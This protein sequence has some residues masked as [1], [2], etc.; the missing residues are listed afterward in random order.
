MAKFIFITGGVVSSLGKGI[1]ASSIGR[2]LK[3]KGFKIFMQKFD[4][5]INVD[6]GTLSPY[7]HGEVYV[8]DDG[9]ETDLDLGHYER[10]T[11]ESLTKLSNITTG[12]IYSEV[13]RKEREGKYLGKTVQVIP[14]ITNEIKLQLKRAEDKSGADII[15]TEIG[16][17]V[18]DIESLP[19]LEAIRQF[20]RERGIENT[21]FVH[22]VLLPY[23]NKSGEIKTKPAQHSTKELGSLGIQPDMIVL[24]SEVNINNE[25]R[26]KISLFCD[27]KKENVFLSKDVDVIYDVV[28]NLYK[29]KID[30]QIC[31]HFKLT[32]CDA[33]METWENLVKKIKNLKSTIKIALVGKYV[34]LHD[35][36]LSVVEALNAAGYA[37]D[38]K[39]EIGWINSEELD[40]VNAKKVLKDYHGIVVPGGFG[41]RG[42]EGK[43]AAL[44]YAR[45]HQIP[46]LGICFGL[47]LMAIEFARN[48]LKLPDA[49][50]TEF[51]PLCENPI[52]DLLENQYEGISLGGT[53]RL[54]AY[55]L[56]LSNDS[57][58]YPYYHHFPIFERHR[59]R[60]EFNN[61]YLQMFNDNGMFVSGLNPHSGLV[62]VMELKNH[63][64][65]VSSQFHPEFKSRPNHPHPFFLGLI[66][67]AKEYRALKEDANI[68]INQ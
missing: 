54:G 61:K 12:R 3:N 41:E 18:G 53:L 45:L 11:N 50:T 67:H 44:K 13:I 63:P 49:N 65:Y 68:K 52:I 57:K 40:D 8:T 28:L 20:R 60:Y 26:E 22:C 16:G 59:H 43:I 46:L 2:I 66:A 51:K 30:S 5:Y 24:R 34:S 38:E 62:E 33:K 48:V 35:A 64:Y 23:L 36:Y 58:V 39:I 4:P 14:H 19:F 10:F 7:Q 17:T 37:Y 25:I 31:Q 27:V 6:P 42:S 15:I 9:A 29:Q 56:S 32:N 1:V 47:Q 55:E 21:L